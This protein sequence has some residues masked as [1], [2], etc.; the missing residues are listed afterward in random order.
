M[1]TTTLR[2]M[3]MIL[4]TTEAEASP[5]RALAPAPAPAP[6]PVEAVPAKAPAQERALRKLLNLASVPTVMMRTRYPRRLR[7][8][9]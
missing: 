1:E 2:T 7:K 6:V 8:R 3:G 4:K 9:E 5:V